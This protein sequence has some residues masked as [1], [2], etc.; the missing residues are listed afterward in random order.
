MQNANPIIFAFRLFYGLGSFVQALRESRSKYIVHEVHVPEEFW[1]TYHCK[2]GTKM[3]GGGGA[4]HVW[5][6]SH[7]FPRCHRI[8]ILFQTQKTVRDIEN[9]SRAMS[10][11]EICGGM[12]PP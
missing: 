6:T 4:K 8:S 1:G 9:L 11:A 2:S 10:S 3:Q 12:C 7:G 5:Q